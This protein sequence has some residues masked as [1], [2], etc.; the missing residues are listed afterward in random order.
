MRRFFAPVFVFFLFSTGCVA[1]GPL[2]APD[3]DVV[4]TVT[5]DIEITNTRDAAAFDMAMLEAMPVKQFETTTIWTEGKNSFVGVPLRHVL[6]FLGVEAGTLRA[7]AINDYSVEMPVDS[8]KSDAPIIAYQ[9]DGN[10][11]SRRQ[12]GPLWIVFPYDSD[13]EYRSELVYSRSIWQLD[14]L[15]VTR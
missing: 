14:R 12:K 8:L 1:A 10:P 13:A 6:E 5:G 9:R 2:A 7:T 3:G 15:E 4:L 11:M